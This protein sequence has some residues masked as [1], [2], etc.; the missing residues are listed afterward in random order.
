LRSQLW[1][2]K[3]MIIGMM[4]K[5][6]YRVMLFMGQVTSRWPVM[7]QSVM[8]VSVDCTPCGIGSATRDGSVWRRIQA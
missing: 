1:T 2:A 7:A 8:I 3:P 4:K 6:R 5:K